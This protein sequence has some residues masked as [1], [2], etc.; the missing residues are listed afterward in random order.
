MTWHITL[1]EVKPWFEQSSGK[2]HKTQRKG[3][4]QN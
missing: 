3:E 4:R 2:A 1:Q